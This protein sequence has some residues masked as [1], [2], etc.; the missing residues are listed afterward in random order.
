MRLIYMRVLSANCQ[1]ALFVPDSEEA[2]PEWPT[3]Q[4]LVVGNSG[5]IYVATICEM[6]G[7][8]AIEVCV[9]R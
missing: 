6:D 9:G 7:E 3:G 2:P 1:V 4:E 8:V 5:A